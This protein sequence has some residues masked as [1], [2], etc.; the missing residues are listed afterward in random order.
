MTAT[1]LPGVLKLLVPRVIAVNSNTFQIYL[2]VNCHHNLFEAK[3]TRFSRLQKKPLASNKNCG[4]QNY[5]NK[6]IA[7]EFVKAQKF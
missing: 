3:K 4:E 5:T 6:T 1:C 2:S 7:K